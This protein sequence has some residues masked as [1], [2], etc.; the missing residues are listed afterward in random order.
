MPEISTF[1]KVQPTIL[2]PVLYPE[3]HVKLIQ[4]GFTKNLGYC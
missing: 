2:F 4:A 3:N 1:L